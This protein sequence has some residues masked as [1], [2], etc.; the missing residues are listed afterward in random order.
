MNVKKIIS[1][2]H[3]RL[4]AGM[5][6]VL[7]TTAMASAQQAGLDSVRRKFDRYRVNHLQ[8]KLYA[9]LDQSFYLTGE[10]MW[11]KLYLVDGATHSPSDV[12]K[13][14]YLEVIDKD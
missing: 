11:F 3:T 10:T 6:M 1:F 14:A 5:A 4:L 8:E 12:S 13:V 9:H 7:L 2:F